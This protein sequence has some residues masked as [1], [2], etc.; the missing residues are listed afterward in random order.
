MIC[1]RRLRRL[2]I[3][4][5]LGIAVAASAA[6]PGA[7]RDLAWPRTDFSKHTVDLGEIQS[8][9]PPKDG[10]PAIDHPKFE[11]AQ[12]ADAWLD[13][14][15]PVISLQVGGVARAYPLQILVYHE[16]VN[17]VV[18]GVPVAVTFCPLCHAAMVFDRRVGN[19]VLDF[20]TTGRLRKSDL[21]MYDRQSESWWQQFTGRGIVGRYAG[22]GLKQL[23][24]YLVAYQDFKAAHPAGEVL[25]RP[26]EYA[27]PYGRNPYRGYDR[28]DSRP[29]L[30]HDPVDSRLPPMERVLSVTLGAAKQRLYPLAVLREQPVINDWVGKTPVVVL[31]KPGTLSALDEASI[32]DSRTVASAAAFNRELNGE[33]LE[34]AL[35]DGA[36]IDTKTT[37][38]WN[39]LGH[40]IA[41]KLKG[42]RLHPVE[43]GVHFAFA[44]LAFNPDS[45]I[46]QTRQREDSSRPR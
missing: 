7:T 31:S 34:F 16:I 44:W 35:R 42:Q 9:G 19:E 5:L 32:R 21:V 38:Q 29:F 26:T 24:S 12:K 37:S 14:R 11:R 4:V 45:E 30:F 2:L 18:A 46:Y 10:I 22:T 8:G 33:V 15:E 43:S 39:I 1:V 3:C 28:I 40:A 41:G 6:P 23:H 17:D 27:R 25:S 13:P 36:I 20:G